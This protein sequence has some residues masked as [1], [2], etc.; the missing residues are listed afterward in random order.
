M[1]RHGFGTWA[2]IHE[3]PGQRV[4]QEPGNYLLEA[5]APESNHRSHNSL[6]EANCFGSPMQ[7]EVDGCLVI[8]V[9]VSKPHRKGASCWVLHIGLRRSSMAKEKGPTV[10]V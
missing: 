2:V 3:L 1:W 9:V 4:T 6:L 10:V 7:R 5:S 8:T